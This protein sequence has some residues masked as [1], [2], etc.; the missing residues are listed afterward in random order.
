MIDEL[1]RELVA[2]GIRGPLRE[3]ILA[4]VADHLACDPDAELGDPRDLARQFAD[5]LGTSLAR[6]AAVATFCGLAL[7]APLVVAPQAL[8]NSY[9][10]IA[11]GSTPVLT[12]LALLAMFVAPQVAFV[13]GSLA[14]LRARALRRER[15]VPAEE[16]RLLRRRAAVGVAAGLATTA[17]PVLYAINFWGQLPLWWETLAVASAAAAAVPLAAVSLSIARAGNPVVRVEGAA[18]D[19]SMDLG[20]LR[21]R[22]APAQ[23]VAVAGASVA[24]LALGGGWYAEHSLTEG[25]LRGGAEAVAF[26]AGYLALGRTLGIRGR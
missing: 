5:E 12:V 23:L 26:A 25:V 18:G 17:A 22:V 6:R 13:A 4:E 24:L 3:R 1:G 2:A 21:S 8:L 9:P 11:S 15:V 16:V 7:A 20:P 19:L 10:D 14:L